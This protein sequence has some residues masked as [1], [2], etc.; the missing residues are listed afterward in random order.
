MAQRTV[1]AANLF[2]LRGPDTQI[3]FSTTSFG[4][5]PQFSYSGP[6]GKHRFSGDEIDTQST[7]LGTEVTVTLESI[8]DLHTITLTVVLPHV[9]Q[10]PG[11]EHRFKTI[12]IFTT[13]HTT[14]AG[15]P[16]VAQSYETIALRGVA[17]FVAA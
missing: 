2:E 4:G 12:G 13:N 10:K 8:P 9:E 16:P 1:V 5:G 15:P 7:A 17:K 14:I 3:T 11:E 6:K